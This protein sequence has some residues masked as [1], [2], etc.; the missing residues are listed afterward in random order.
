M[1][2]LALSFILLAGVLCAS[3]VATTTVYLTSANSVISPYTMSIYGKTTAALCVDPD[4]M[5][6][7]GQKN[8]WTA[9][10]SNLTGDLSHTYQDSKTNYEEEA[11]IFTQITKSGISSETQKE[12][13]EAD[14]YIADSSYNSDLKSFLTDSNAANEK[15]WTGSSHYQEYLNI[16]TDL[17]NALNSVGKMNYSYFQIV[18]DASMDDCDRNQEFM[19]DATPEPATYALFGLALIITG[20]V[21]QFARR[22]AA[23]NA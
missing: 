22:K 23:A 17:S 14:W 4:D 1:K 20:A 3:P 11:Y 19:I 2:K 12:L 16:Q 13:Q 21:R 9:Y 6:S 18:S 15:K 7:V 8:G 5:S 10:V